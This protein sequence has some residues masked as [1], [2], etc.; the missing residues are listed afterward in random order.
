MGARREACK[1]TNMMD[2][3]IQSLL[4]DLQI[5]DPAMIEEFYPRVRDRE[6]V[7]ALRCSKSG[8]IFLS[9]PQVINKAHYVEKTEFSYWA[10]DSRALALRETSEDDERRALQFARLIRGRVWLD[11]GTGLGGILDLLKDKAGEI[12]AVE[13]QSGP[14]NE[15]CRLG[16]RVYASIEEIPAD[17][18]EVVT[19]FHVLEHLTEPITTLRSIFQKMGSGAKLVVE[20]PQAR[21]FLMT[22]MNRAEFKA[23]SLWSEHLILHTRQSLEVFL[24]TAGFRNIKIEGFQRYPL[25]N[26]LYWLA[27]G[28]PGGHKKWSVLRTPELDAAYAALL[29]RM[30]QTD[31]LIAIA[32]K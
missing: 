22:F 17:R 19:M 12:W 16:Y 20:V 6:D 29:E 3:P 11:F 30:D 5:I 23:F 4:V 14:R 24:R 10:A 7:K 2:N 8:V 28:K 26:H 32:E 18:M 25:A 9:K 21:D 31:T 27:E 15:L 1:G 13:L